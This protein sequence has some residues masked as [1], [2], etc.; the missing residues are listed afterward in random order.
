M[1]LERV[2]LT[3]ERGRAEGQRLC[4]SISYC[5]GPKRFFL[6]T[7]CSDVTRKCNKSIIRCELK[8]LTP[9]P[10]PSLKFLS[11][12][13]TRELENNICEEGLPN[14]AGLPTGVALSAEIAPGSAVF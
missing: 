5:R 2:R 1:I 7:N 8:L 12:D 6:S 14:R 9:L 10:L 3:W 4:N 11:Y 13:P